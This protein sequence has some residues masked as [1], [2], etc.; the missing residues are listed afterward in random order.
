MSFDDFVNQLQETQADY[1]AAKQ[2]GCFP[3]FGC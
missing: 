3:F 2:V 1:V